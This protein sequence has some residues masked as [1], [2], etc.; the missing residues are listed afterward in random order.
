M[1]SWKVLH[2]LRATVEIFLV[3]SVIEE[4]QNK[5]LHVEELGLSRFK[6]EI[7]KKMTF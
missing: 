4:E 3:N 6:W 1:Y 2:E 7:L 5:K